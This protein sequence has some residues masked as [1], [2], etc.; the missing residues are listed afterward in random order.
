MKMTLPEVLTVMSVKV[1][2]SIRRLATGTA[3]EMKVMA[4]VPDATWVVLW[5]LLEAIVKSVVAFPDEDSTTIPCITDELEALFNETELFEMVF[6]MVP[7]RSTVEGLNEYSTQTTC[8]Y[9][10]V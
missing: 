3:D 7:K 1:L 5:K 4:P 9:S 8:C 10:S 2:A 6:V